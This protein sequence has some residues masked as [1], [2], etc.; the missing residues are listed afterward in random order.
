[1]CSMADD[2]DTIGGRLGRLISFVPD[3]DMQSVDRLA[4][5]KSP[6]HTAQI[7]RG[8]K[9]SPAAAT[10]VALA[11]V[12]GTSAEW[13]VSG[14]DAPSERRVRAAVKAARARVEGGG[15]HAP[16]VRAAAKRAKPRARSAGR[17]R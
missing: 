7:V 11:R 15:G 12:L 17:S 13:L 2:L 8:D 1:M 16:R 3:L 5:L 14:G 9:P 10:I 4:G 6:G